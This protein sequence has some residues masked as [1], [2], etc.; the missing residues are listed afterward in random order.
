MAGIGTKK[1]L[2]F[3]NDWEGDINRLYQREEYAAKVRAE[4]EQKTQYYAGLLKKGHGTNP[5]A[6]K[7]LD[8]FYSKVNTELADFVIENPNFETDVNAMQKF[9]SISD[10]YLNNDIL[11]KDL[12]VK[13]QF[14]DLQKA[15]G[16]LTEE[17]IESEMERYNAYINS[18]PGDEVSPYVFMNYK[19]KSSL[20]LLGEITS[21]LQAV[22]G[23]TQLD[24]TAHVFY[25][26][27]EVP[28]LNVFNT[29]T[30]TYTDK[31]NKIVMDNEYKAFKEQN[32]QNSMF[33]DVI[34]Y[35]THKAKNATPIEM[36]TVAA[37]YEYEQKMQQ[38]YS[39]SGAGAGV[40]PYAL[41]T[42]F[43]KL[44]ALLTDKDGNPLLSGETNANDASVAFTKFQTLNKPAQVSQA[45]N[46]WAYD[47]SG[48]PVK[49]DF[50]TA[51]QVTSISHYVNIGG[52]AYARGTIKLNT[53]G[54]IGLGAE[55]A[56]LIDSTAKKLKGWGFT[57]SQ[58]T[59]VPLIDS[60]GQTTRYM[61]GQEWTGEV[62]IPVNPSAENA[63]AYDNIVG[64]QA[65]ATKA[66]V[67]NITSTMSEILSDPGLA[68]NY[69]AQTVGVKN[70]KIDKTLTEQEGVSTAIG[71]FDGYK[72]A[73][74]LTNGKMRK[75]TE[76][77][78]QMVR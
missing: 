9:M 64:G 22:D 35:W 75:I 43:P 62:L 39:D 74:N 53:S 59:S 16:D 71:E 40:I 57:S 44:R 67:T 58:V 19:R 23:E 30:S 3:V 6:E 13:Q 2:S 17:E 76:D 18:E 29:V 11:R 78:W 60:G 49:F 21:Q 31:K 8:Q 42:E 7:D 73:I 20:D 70:F 32:P 54:E 50:P 36:K 37:D 5:R 77:P 27:R 68:R 65:N 63:I 4:K 15:S 55:N 51:A 24:N 25:R 26:N 61:K 69:F 12:Q 46:I 48:S 56:G 45:D 66:A 33:P 41:T 14:E 10:K 38:K 34:T 1:G 28:I 52:V 47:E 72:V